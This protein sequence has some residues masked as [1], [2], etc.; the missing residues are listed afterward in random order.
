MTGVLLIR[1]HGG[2]GKAVLYSLFKMVMEQYY[3][4]KKSSKKKKRTRNQFVGIDA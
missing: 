4:H 3:F 2:Q 1:G